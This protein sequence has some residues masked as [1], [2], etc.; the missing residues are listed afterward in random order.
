MSHEL[1]QKIQG[2]QFL[3]AAIGTKPWRISQKVGSQKQKYV[4]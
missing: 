2:T 4:I 1:S 3:S